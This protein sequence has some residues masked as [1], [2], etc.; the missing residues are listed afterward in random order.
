M[1]D[2]K[3]LRTDRDEPWKMFNLAIDLGEQNDLAEELP[4]QLKVL[5]DEFERWQ[6]DAQRDVPHPTTA[7]N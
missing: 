2:W 3:I 6:R 5:T 7:P 4:E 1:G